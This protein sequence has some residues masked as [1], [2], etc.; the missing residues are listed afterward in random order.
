MDTPVAGVSLYPRV[1][2]G[3][4]VTGSAVTARK[5]KPGQELT[6]TWTVKAPEAY[7]YIDIPVVAK[8]DNGLEDEQVTKV[9]VWKPL[10]AGWFYVSDLPFTGTA[11]KDLAA[12]GNPIAIRRVP[13]GKGLG[14]TSNTQ[15]QLTLDGCTEFVADVGVDD[16]AGLDVARQKV[17]GTAGFVVQGDGKTLAD[18]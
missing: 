10:P 18:T 12:N 13:Y 8:F 5:L 6:G 17:G 7:G 14:A 1:P 4:T 16:Q 3:W 11:Q 15:V 9:H 2:A